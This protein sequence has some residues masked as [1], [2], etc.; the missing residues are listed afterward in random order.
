MKISNEIR[1]R[2]ILRTL[3]ERMG[4]APAEIG[5]ACYTAH[6][7]VRG[8]E[9]ALAEGDGLV[10]VA[11]VNQECSQCLSLHTSAPVRALEEADE[12]YARIS[13]CPHEWA[14]EPAGA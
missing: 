7:T 13:E 4:A 3:L 14:R 6:L 8:R 12:L 11:V 9:F 1:D 2:M 5:S 10:G